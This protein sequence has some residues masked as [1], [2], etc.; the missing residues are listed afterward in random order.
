[1]LGMGWGMLPE[2][3]CSAGLA[4][5]SLVAL[6]DRPILMPLYW[7]RW[8]LDSPVLDGLSRVIAEEA[9]AALPQTR[10]GF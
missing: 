2:M 5:G 3:Q 10:G 6:G 1:A 9:S 8:N 7:Q 4:D